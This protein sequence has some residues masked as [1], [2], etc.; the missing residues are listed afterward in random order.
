M[1]TTAQPAKKLASNGP[2]EKIYV[3]EGRD[4]NGKTARGEIRA[5]GEHVVK[6]MLRRQVTLNARG[7]T[8]HF[9]A[10][11]ASPVEKL[12]EALAEARSAS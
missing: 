8:F 3:Y 6:S 12:S 1:A 9:E 10:H 11:K 5:T 7:G 4:K 2:S